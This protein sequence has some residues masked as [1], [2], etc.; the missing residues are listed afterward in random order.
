M[1]KCLDDFPNA[2]PFTAVLCVFG[3]MAMLGYSSPLAAQSAADSDPLRGLNSSVEA[4]VK[5][6]SPSVVQI[7]VTGYGAVGESD[8]GN[9]GLTVGRQHAIGSGFIIDPAGY[10]MTNAHVVNDAQRIQV[11]LPAVPSDSTPRGSLSYRG[12]VLAAHVVGI[13]PAVDLAVIK[14]DGA[15]N[16]PCLLYTSRCV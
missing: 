14:I 13:A 11:I 12:E 9:A 15:T 4:L 1:P 7:A 5:K 3:C 2:L 8:R 10:I 16:L 6:V